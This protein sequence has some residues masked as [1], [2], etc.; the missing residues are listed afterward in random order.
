MD[1]IERLLVLP[2]L[3]AI[4]HNNSTQRLFLIGDYETTIEQ[5]KTNMAKFDESNH[6]FV[7]IEAGGTVIFQ[8]QGNFIERST[9][10]NAGMTF[11]VATGCDRYGKCDWN[12]DRTQGA[13]L[14][15]NMFRNV[16]YYDISAVEAM[17]SFR[18]TMKSVG[19]GSD[20]HS[21]GKV[22]GFDMIA[23]CIAAPNSKIT[24][25]SGVEYCNAPKRVVRKL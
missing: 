19:S 22:C 16:L 8:S 13:V 23:G 14:E 1:D 12:A 10:K 4:V 24:T 25:K 5:Y 3:A 20:C 15:W 21:E 2:G 7:A 11:W 6:P 18:Y 9:G 17:D